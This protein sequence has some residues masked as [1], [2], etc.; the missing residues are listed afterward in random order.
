[1]SETRSNGRIWAEGFARAIPWAIVFSAAFLLTM[2]V[3]LGVLKPELKKAI[4]F[5]E[6]SAVSATMHTVFDDEALR[7]NTKE[8]IA[9]A[10][11]TVDQEL[12]E[13]H[14]KLTSAKK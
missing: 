12:V 5:A 1:M 14:K 11:K 6:Q 4:T 2:G 10:V 3:F 13:P 9:Y 7:K 8:A